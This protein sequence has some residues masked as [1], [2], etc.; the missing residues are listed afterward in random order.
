M[1]T[2]GATTTTGTMIATVIGS[3]AAP[4]SNA[5]VAEHLLEVEVQEEPHQDPALLGRAHDAEHCERETRGGR[6]GTGQVDRAASGGAA[7]MSVGVAAS[8]TTAIGMFT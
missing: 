1:I 8:T 3:S 4:P 6:H 2:L 5:P 7:G